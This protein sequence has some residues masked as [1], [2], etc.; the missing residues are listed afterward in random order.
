M[1]TWNWGRARC[2]SRT[3]E[4]SGLACWACVHWAWPVG[5]RTQPSDSRAPAESRGQGGGLRS[6]CPCLNLGP[7]H[8]RRAAGASLASEQVLCPLEGA[9]QF[10]V[11]E[12]RSEL[13]VSEG[14]LQSALASRRLADSH[15]VGDRM[16]ARGAPAHRSPWLLPGNEPESHWYKWHASFCC[17]VFYV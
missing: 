10:V 6:L 1:L 11:T 4:A 5:L 15:A 14:L 2:P 7:K 3:P 8:S 13:C 12:R 16:V 17:F 9:E